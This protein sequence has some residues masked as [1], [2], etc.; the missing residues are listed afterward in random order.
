MF[1][2]SEYGVADVYL[3]TYVDRIKALIQ[4]AHPDF[5]QE[6]KDK[7]VT[8]PLIK[9]EDFVGYSLFD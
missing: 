2:V 7:I 4:I 5:R 8:T 3:K 6:L 9:E 1:I